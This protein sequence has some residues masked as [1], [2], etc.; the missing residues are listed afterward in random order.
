MSYGRR[1]IRTDAKAITPDN[2]VDE[3]RKARLDHERNRNEINRLYDYYR[4]KTKILGKVKEVRES[5]NWKITENRAYEIVR[6]HKGYTFGEPIQY[7]RRE[8]VKE[9]LADDEIASDINALNAHMASANKAACDERLASWMYIGG[10]AY[11][12]VLPNKNW[13]QDDEEPPFELFALDPRRTCIVYSNDVRERP[14]FSFCCVE[15]EHGEKV[16]SGYTDEFYFEF[17]EHGGEP[18][19]TP[20]ALGMIPIIEYPGNDARLGVF[21]TVLSLLDALDT[22]QSNRMDDVVQYVNSFLAILGGELD[23]QTYKKL[24]EWKTLC[25]PEGTDAKYLSPAMNQND[26]QTFKNDICQAILTICGV[27]NRNGGSSTSDT[28]SAVILRDG[29]EAAEAHAKSTETMFKYSET[30]F[31]KLVLR[32]MRDTVGTKVKL[33]DIVP[34]FT[35]RNY[36]NIA[37][38]SQVLI[39]ML[40]N[41]NIHPE[42]AFSHCGMFADPESAYLQSMAWKEEN[43]KKAEEK[44]REI[45][46]N[47]P[48]GSPEGD[49]RASEG[50]AEEKEGGEA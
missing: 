23:E 15:R 10:T 31:L 35:R 4:G 6:F 1:V 12:L 25:L 14:M 28:G 20:H 40:N 36:E 26:V 37:S 29:W 34:H 50:A 5:I 30:R 46:G 18:V 44:A 45:Q 24:N 16:Y 43:E 2:L 41:P 9:E 27:P 22:L 11:R 19:I 42:L 32:I 8:K 3:I 38:K 7:I 47:D 21:E 39:A 13:G 48:K 17:S 33:T 49:P